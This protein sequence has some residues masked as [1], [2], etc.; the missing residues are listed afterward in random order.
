MCQQI[1]DWEDMLSTLRAEEGSDFFSSRNGTTGFT[2]PTV[3]GQDI[4][5]LFPDQ[6]Y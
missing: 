1:N 5:L 6:K 4:F 3:S 2:D